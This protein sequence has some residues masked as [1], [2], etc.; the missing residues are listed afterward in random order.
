MPSTEVDPNAKFFIVLNGG[1][2]HEDTAET[3]ETIE[4]VLCEAGRRWQLHVVEDAAQLHAVARQAVQD[5][6]AAR[7][8]VV[9]A[10][11][12]GTINAVAQATLGSECP[13]GVLPQGTFN[14]FSR[15]HGIPFDTAEATRL[16]VSARA[17]PVQAGMV[18]DRLF[19]VNASIGLYPR[20]LEDREAKKQQLGRSRLVALWAAL[21]T[22]MQQHRPLRLRIDEGRTSRIMH[23]VTLFVGNNRLQL[24]QVGIPEAELLGHGQLAAIAVRPVGMLKMLWLMLRSA[25]GALGAAEDIINFAFRRITVKPAFAFGRRPVKVAVD[26]E[27]LWLQPPIEFS[28]ASELLYLLKPEPGAAEKSTPG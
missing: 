24:E 4:R 23:T 1:S 18:N 12:D 21:G 17:H 22:L 8:V 11:G 16:L 20:L 25:F 19:L 13:F 6:R 9:A 28:V 26:G 7:G 2:G 3:R 10:G 5:A 14:Y 27:V 15:T